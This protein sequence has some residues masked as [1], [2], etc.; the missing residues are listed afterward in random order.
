MSFNDLMPPNPSDVVLLQPPLTGIEQSTIV[1]F[2]MVPAISAR[3]ELQKSCE[4]ISSPFEVDLD[5][6]NKFSSASRSDLCGQI[7]S[8]YGQMIQGL[9]DDK[10]LTLYTSCTITDPRTA[11]R[12]PTSSELLVC[13]LEVTVYGPLKIF[14]E[15]GSWFDEYGVYLQDPR[16]CHLEVKYCNPQRLSSDDIASCPSLIEVVS[17]TSIPVNLQDIPR[18][19]ELLD[20]LSSQVDLDETPQPSAILGNLKRHQK[21]ALT[22]MLRRERGWNFRH[23]YPDIWEILDTEQGRFFFNLVSETHQFEEPAPFYGGII[24]DP[25]GLGKTLTMIALA[26]TDLDSNDAHAQPGASGDDK[27][28][29]PATLIVVPPPLLGTWEDQLSEHV[30]AGG[31]SCRRHHGK[32]RLTA[33]GDLNGVNIVLTTYHTISAEWNS[34]RAHF[35]RNG[36]SRM[37]H[38]VC[39]LDA[40][41]RWAV[42]GT[43]IQNRLS[44]IASLFKFIRAYPH[45]D[46]KCFEA[47]ISRLWKLGEDEEAVKRLKRLSACLLLRR[48]KDTISLPPRRDTQCPVDFNQEERVLYDEMR[49]KAVIS[50]DETLQGD[51]EQARAGVYVNVLQQIESLRLICNLGVHYHTRQDNT[52]RST[53]EME[54]WAGIA[55]QTF[56]IQQ[57]MAP[58]I[59]LRCSS[60]IDVNETLLDDPAATHQAPKFT[61]CLKFVCSDCTQKGFKRKNGLACGHKPSCP[62]APISTSGSAFES[63]SCLMSPQTRT[64]SLRLPSKIEALVADIKALPQD[65]KCLTLTVVTRA[66]LM[67]PHWN[68]TLEEQALARIYRIGQTKEVTTVRF[69]VRDSFE[70]QVM[71]IQE[72]KKH[73]AGV[74]LSPHDGGQTDESLGGLHRLRQLL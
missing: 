45:T 30:V 10:T 2:G 46:P 58:V 47:D 22:F 8:D 3:C 11:K 24:A 44:D 70:Q 42:T 6:S 65:T 51:S 54:E 67:E 13:S 16:K 56:N 26:A 5:S 64:S 12:A 52:T 18:R 23:Q 68:P 40:V 15:I 43:P 57:Q 21:Q 29:I 19:P 62:V 20:A 69:Y 48:A 53:Q 32:N 66:Y 59:C 38:A 60:I 4:A 14:D 37:A 50:I 7:P 27:R 73:L 71:E 31:L 61:R 28:Y 34:D 49:K 72:S 1:C 39:A 33:T 63:S 9:L 55:Q 41:A 25:M 36:N 74:L 35:I 17:R